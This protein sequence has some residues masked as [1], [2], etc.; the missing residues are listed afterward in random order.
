MCA[1][2][3]PKHVRAPGFFLSGLAY[4]ANNLREQGLAVHSFIDAIF[5]HSFGPGARVFRKAW[6]YR[7]TVPFSQV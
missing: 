3:A 4:R 1:L 7:L 6:E 2:T 5:G